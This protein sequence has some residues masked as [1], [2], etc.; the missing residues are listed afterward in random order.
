MR[1]V[2]QVSGDFAETSASA[3]GP[4]DPTMQHG[5]APAAPVAWAADRMVSDTPMRIT[6]LTLDLLRLV[7]VAPL[8]IRCELVR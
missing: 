5:A 1:S 7:P 2:Y 3:A 8:E 6:R 4:W